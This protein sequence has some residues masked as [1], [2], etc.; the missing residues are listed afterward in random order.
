MK[1]TQTITKS[2]IAAFLICVATNSWAQS[3][4]DM[5]A[6]MDM[7]APAENHA[8]LNHFAGEWTST[9]TFWMDPSQPPQEST[10]ATVSEIIMGGR[11]LEE[12]HSGTIMGMP[13]E[14]RSITAYDKTAGEY[15]STWI[16]NFG[17]GVMVFKGNVDA[18]GKALDMV[19]DYFDPMTK[20]NQKH[21]IHLTVIDENNTKMEYFVKS[22]AAEEFKS[23]EIAYTKK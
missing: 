1:T 9:N 21:R 17:T 11:Y 12:R 2:V 4:A 18:S 19:A 13:F 8:F 7:M 3:E 14:G 20:Q 22:E 16:D 15:I 10:G 5:Q 6:W 23:M